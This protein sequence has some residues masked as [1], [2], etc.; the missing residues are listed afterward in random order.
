VS[1]SEEKRARQEAAGIPDSK[2]FIDPETADQPSSMDGYHINGVLIAELN[3]PPQVLAALDYYATDE[4]MAERNARPMVREPSGI[5]LGADGFT[6]ALDQRRDDV[7]DRDMDMYEARDPLKEVASSFTGVGMRPKFL[8]AAS[9]KE[10]G[11]T[12]DWD[13]VKYPDGHKQH[14]DPV[15]VK[16]MVLG[17]M[18]ERKA[19]A[20]N[21]FYRGRGN[22]LLKQIGEKHQ[23]EGGLADQ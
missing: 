12:G 20:R 15:M 4:G 2:P 19:I 7:I 6:K 8:S 23:A 16:G 11:G 10:G 13:V 9:V 3:L 5:E 17:Q 14:G 22:Q 21:N 1:K 18:P